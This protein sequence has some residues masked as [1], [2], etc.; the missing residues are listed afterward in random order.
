MSISGD[1]V[2]E[3]AGQGID[4]VRTKINGHVLE[5]NVENLVLDG[6][7]DIRGKGNT[8]ANV[9]TG[10]SGKNQLAGHGGQ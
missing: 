10:N 9:I 6:T 5:N 7:D 4:E 1:T 2:S 8:L 3:K